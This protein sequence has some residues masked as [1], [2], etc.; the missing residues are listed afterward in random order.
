MG[1]TTLATVND[2]TTGRDLGLCDVFD[3]AMEAYEAKEI[4]QW[5]EGV[6]SASELLSDS[7]IERLGIDADT[8]I[9]IEI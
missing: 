3:D 7:E 2:Y 4:G 6:I 1:T 5:P 9:W 8:T